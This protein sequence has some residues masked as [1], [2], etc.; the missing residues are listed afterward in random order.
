MFRTILVSK[1]GFGSIV[2]FDDDLAQL[3]RSL[4]LVLK[5]NVLQMLQLH[6]D[7]RF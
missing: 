1:H 5:S 7:Q 6:F 2:V 3:E 4:N